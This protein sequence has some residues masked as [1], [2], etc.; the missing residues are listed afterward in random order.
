[1][2]L[3]PTAKD[4]GNYLQS[5]AHHFDLIAH[6]QF[7]T[8]IIRVQ[9]D[10]SA[11]K[12]IVT[13][14]TSASPTLNVHLFDRIVVATGILNTRHQVKI[15][16]AEKFGGEVMH[17]REFKDASR[18]VGKNVLVVGFGATGCDTASFL[19]EAGAENVFLSHRGQGY[20]VRFLAALRGY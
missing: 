7:S 4:I 2:S 12:W 16:G 10:E 15:L 17:S 1:M 20:L 18:Y 3:H 19:K 14:R 13:T 11:R 5:Y 6:I 9:R 8:K